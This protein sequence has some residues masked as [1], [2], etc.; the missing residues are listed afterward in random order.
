MSEQTIKAA[1]TSGQEDLAKRIKDVENVIQLETNTLNLIFEGSYSAK[2]CR[3]ISDV[4]GYHEGFIASLKD[5]LKAL[6][7]MLPK[8]EPESQVKEN[9]QL[10][11]SEV[12]A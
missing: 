8:A 4:V 9:I 2:Y 7:E 3:I 12:K 5:Q 10:E 11:T 6:N 1:I